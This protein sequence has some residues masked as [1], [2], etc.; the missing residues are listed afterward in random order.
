METPL[1]VFLDRIKWRN[2]HTPL[3]LFLHFAT[4]D[5]VWPAASYSVAMLSLPLMGY[6]PLNYTKITP[7]HTSRQEF[8]LIREKSN[9]LRVSTVA[10][11]AILPIVFFYI[12]LL[13]VEMA[14]SFHNHPASK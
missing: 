3:L 13:L 5:T 4:M 2:H 6:I 1:R 10:G 8:D 9:T 14:G 11:Y 7:H 12:Y